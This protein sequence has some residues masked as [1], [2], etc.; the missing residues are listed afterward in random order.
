MSDLLRR[1]AASYS[2]LAVCGRS[3]HL[4]GLQ[5]QAGLQGLS[6]LLQDTRGQEHR[7]REDGALSLRGK[8]ETIIEL[9]YNLIAVDLLTVGVSA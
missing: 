3:R 2:H 1:N 8:S 6:L 4:R 7:S 5:E 9:K